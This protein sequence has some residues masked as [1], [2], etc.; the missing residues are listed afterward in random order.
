MPVTASLC[1]IRGL[2]EWVWGETMTDLTLPAEL[3]AAGGEG[4]VSS[5]ERVSDSAVLPAKVIMKNVH[6]M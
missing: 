3:R 2:M 6:K 1:D 5:C 4:Q